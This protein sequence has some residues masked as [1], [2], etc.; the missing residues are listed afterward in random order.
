MTAQYACDVTDLE[1]ESALAVELTAADG[2]PVDV[3]VV[4]DSDG[5]WHA[6][7]DM[8]THG[9]VSLSDGEV[10]GC[11]IECWLHG[12]VFDLKTGQPTTPPASQPVNVYPVSIDGNDVLVD[13]D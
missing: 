3:A 2:S 10:E 7:D 9:A 11:M 4:R 1:P 8:C 13:I 12:S 5:E 6:I